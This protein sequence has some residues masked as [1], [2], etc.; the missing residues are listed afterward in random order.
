MYMCN[1][2]NTCN[3]KDRKT[4]KYCSDCG[5][6]ENTLTAKIIFLKHYKKECGS[7][8]SPKN[9]KIVSL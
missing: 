2:N 3:N 4:S 9:G 1:N 5:P 8:I 6:T 7:K